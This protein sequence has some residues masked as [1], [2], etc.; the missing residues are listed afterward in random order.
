[1]LHRLAAGLLTIACFISFQTNI[2]AETNNE[3]PTRGGGTGGSTFGT[4]GNGGVNLT[5]SNVVTPT[6]PACKTEG[7]TTTCRWDNLQV[8]YILTRLAA[9]WGPDRH[10]L[11]T[12]KAKNKEIQFSASKD[13]PSHLVN[14]LAS[15]ERMAIASSVGQGYFSFYVIANSSNASQVEDHVNDNKVLLN[16]GQQSYQEVGCFLSSG[17]P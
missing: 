15:C 17:N 12:I 5:S 16:I 9:A 10:H 8:D 6:G 14:A 11:L 1:M 7:S 13:A 3:N 2:G 4:G